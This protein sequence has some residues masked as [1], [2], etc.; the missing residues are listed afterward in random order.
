VWQILEKITTITEVRT[1]EKSIAKHAKM[2]AGLDVYRD[3]TK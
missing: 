2:K 1:S 3:T